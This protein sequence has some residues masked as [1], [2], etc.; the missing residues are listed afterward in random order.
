M[1]PLALFTRLALAADP[2]AAPAAEEPKKDKPS[3]SA[4]GTLF[5]HYG[6]DLT[7]SADLANA[8]DLDRAHLRTDAK[9][10]DAWW[11]RV[12]LDANREKEQTLTLVDATGA[13]TDVT[14]PEDARIRVFVKHAWLEWRTP[15]ETGIRVRGGVVD[16]AYIGV[17]EDTLASR[18][19]AK[20]LLDDQKLESTADIGVTA[21]GTHAG[22]VV[23][24]QVGAYNGEGFSDPE[25]GVGKALQARVTVDP[26]A[27]GEKI[28][29][30]ISAF[31]EEDLRPDLDSV[32]IFAGS[33][34]LKH[35]AIRAW[36]EVVG[37]SEADVTGLGQSIAV[38]P[39]IPDVIGFYA[40]FDHW[41]PD[42]AT[43]KDGNTKIWGGVTRE[44]AEKIALAGLFEQ[45]T[46]E[47]DPDVPARA[48]MVR[49]LAGF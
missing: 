33:V 48:V 37:R 31:V 24:W 21:Q 3:V 12:M 14:V 4:S 45:T 38:V 18:Y 36:A 29:L 42:G 19:I 16:T 46:Y 35:E 27:K 1:T 22:D 26:L 25:S 30:P 10:S 39:K 2:A 11:I 20:P 28:G 8:F 40:R 13:A 15:E 43:D 32:M 5:A 49:M 44:F 17:A 9:V 47:A 6:I 7:E 41:D 23:A 34:G